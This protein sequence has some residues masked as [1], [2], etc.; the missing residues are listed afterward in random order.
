M[1]A[2]GVESAKVVRISLDEP[3][4]ALPLE[5]G[6]TH[7]LLVVR[8]GGEV[9]GEVLLP[10]SRGE[11]GVEA[12]RSAL[13]GPLGEPL[14]R[15]RVAHA[16]D[17]ATRASALD[18]APRPP[19]PSV[20]VVVCT[21]GGTEPARACLK[22]LDALDTR[23]AEV[24][25][26]SGPSGRDRGV[27]RSGGDVI[28]FTDG[29]CVADPAWLDALG[30]DFADPLVMVVAGYVGPL[31]VEAGLPGGYARGCERTV[32]DWRSTEPVGAVAGNLLVR[33][34]V[35]EEVGGVDNGSDDFVAR[36]LA[37]GYAVVASPA[38]VVWRPHR[39]GSRVPGALSDRQLRRARRGLGKGPPA[40]R[41]PAPDSPRVV[42]EESPA[43]SVALASYNRRERL[44]QVLEGLARQS[45][46]P[47][48]FEAVVVIDGSTDGS[49]DRVRGLQLPYPVRV[50]E[51]EN[52]GLGARSQPRRG[53]G[54]RPGRG[55]PR[56]RHRARGRLPGRARR[57]P[58]PARARP[59]WPSPT[60]RR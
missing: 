12:Q 56:R 39:D 43:L 6:D 42:A 11:L 59:T 3:L 58:P 45:Y 38:R 57:R 49:A 2:H 53:G 28:A 27:A 50:L 31:A 47:E 14:A 10:V 13:T 17:R 32:H 51:Q 40:S 44:V 46:P 48:R 26:E 35:L 37:A 1:P 41:P 20:S 5:D 60:A 15:R 54:R 23:P 25:V 16:F 9:V 36:V 52:R 29:D 21:R 19:D 55:V 30:G 33:R 4:R 34:R 24:V 8:L 18:A 22:S 7:A